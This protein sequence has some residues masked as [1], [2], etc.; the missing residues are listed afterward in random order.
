[1]TNTDIRKNVFR[2]YPLG[3]SE[4]GRQ[5]MEMFFT[6]HLAGDCQIAPAADAHAVVIDGDGYQA[7]DLL[8]KHLA[9][10]PQHR[11][12]L[13]S[14]APEKHALKNG[15]VVRKP[16]EVGA[17]AG[18]LRELMGRFFAP[19][20]PPQTDQ[21]AEQA[22]S[23]ARFS[24]ANDSILKTKLTRASAAADA[25]PPTVHNTIPPSLSPGEL[26]FYIGSAPDVDLDQ[27][28]A[29]EG[30]FYR[31]DSFLQGHVQRVVTLANERSAIVRMSGA[32]FQTID[33]DPQAKSARCVVPLSGLLASGRV[34]IS[35]QDIGIEFIRPESAI[36]PENPGETYSIESLLWRLALC[37]SRGRLPADASLDASVFV[38]RWP[39]LTRLPVPPYA[40]RILGL[41][42]R[43]RTPLA[44]TAASLNIPQRYVF[45]LY[46]ACNAIGL[47]KLE[48]KQALSPAPAEDSVRAHQKQGLFRM[49]LNKLTGY[50][51]P[52][53]KLS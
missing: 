31:P 49:L 33:I 8:A 47:V 19:P 37:A 16:L 30:I 27:P 25:P 22:A 36:S 3:M 7:G 18:A 15:I 46:S 2:V 44:Q 6:R 39:N 4:R 10:Y 23:S 9:H 48:E 5:T 28:R 51:E 42:S 29:R 40:A 17:F 32:G 21:G 43:Y 45:A 35:G 20:P 11:V 13:L 52:I 1:M 53:V 26:D 14:M 41:W 24:A 34:P 50:G 12:I 38:A